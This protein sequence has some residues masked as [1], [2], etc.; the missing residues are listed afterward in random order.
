MVAHR[1]KSLFTP[2]NVSDVHRHF[3]HIVR[4][5]LQSA[6][7][8]SKQPPTPLKSLNFAAWPRQRKSA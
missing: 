1:V 8:R 7:A 3:Q 6:A 4:K 2:S 5:T